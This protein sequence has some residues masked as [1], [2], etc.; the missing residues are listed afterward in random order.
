[1]RTSWYL[2]ATHSRRT[3]T[4]R[5]TSAQTTTEVSCSCPESF[6]EEP[7]KS[8][9]VIHPR[10][11]KNVSEDEPIRWRYE[12][13]DWWRFLGGITREQN[14]LALKRTPFPP[15]Y[16]THVFL[17]LEEDGLKKALVPPTWIC[18]RSFLSTYGPDVRHGRCPQV[19]DELLRRFKQ[20]DQLLFACASTRF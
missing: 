5:K 19:F 4:K 16:R 1:M 17:N 7:K 12:L 15:T 11:H 8:K 9:E 14:D 18:F 3:S 2:G 10:L 6:V 20:G 13:S